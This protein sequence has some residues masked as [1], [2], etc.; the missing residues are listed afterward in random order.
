MSPIAYD[1]IVTG[2]RP[3]RA[4]GDEPTVMRAVRAS[5]ASAPRERG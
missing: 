1:V 2:R 3:P 5:G 4:S